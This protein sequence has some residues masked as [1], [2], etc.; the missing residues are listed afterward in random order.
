MVRVKIYDEDGQS[1]RGEAELVDCFPDQEAEY[2]AA[3]DEIAK[4]GRYWTGGGASPLV[5]LVRINS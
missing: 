4:A 2:H 5:L 1:L 3:Q